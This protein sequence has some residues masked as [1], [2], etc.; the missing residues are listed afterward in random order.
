MLTDILRVCKS[1]LVLGVRSVSGQIGLMEYESDEYSDSDLR[2][3]QQP[4]QGAMPMKHKVAGLYFFSDFAP[5][6]GR[7]HLPPGLTGLREFIKLALEKPSEFEKLE[8]GVVWKFAGQASCS[9][10]ITI[11]PEEYGPNTVNF[12]SQDWWMENPNYLSWCQ[13]MA[14]LL[15]KP[16]PHAM[17]GAPMQGEMQPQELKRPIG[18]RHG[19]GSRVRTSG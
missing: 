19:R 17:D 14:N 18:V 11:D 7:R 12:G 8:V 9:D 3:K 10:Y 1:P 4:A 2:G 15:N 16:F 6:P 5:G 13:A